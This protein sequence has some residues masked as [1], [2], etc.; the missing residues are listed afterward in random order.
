MEIEKKVL[1]SGD[2]PDEIRKGEGLLDCTDGRYVL[3]M[4][5]EHPMTPL[6]PILNQFWYRYED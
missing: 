3:G 4:P 6:L 5:V 1:H 2:E